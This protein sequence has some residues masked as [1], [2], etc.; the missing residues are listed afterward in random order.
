MNADFFAFVVKGQ[1]PDLWLRTK[2]QQESYLKLRCA[3]VVESLSF[4][5]GFEGSYR[6]KFKEQSLFDNEIG[7]KISNEPFAKP[8]ADRNLGLDLQAGCF[9][10][11]R[12][13]LCIH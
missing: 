4:M 13:R 10:S 3:Q 11:H 5:R 2:I 1:S 7:A 9:Q 8:D 6:L 12:H